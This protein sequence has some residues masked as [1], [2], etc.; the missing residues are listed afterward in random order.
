M[1]AFNDNENQS[2]RIDFTVGLIEEIRK[3]HDVDLFEPME[4]DPP[5]LATICFG[6]GKSLRRFIEILYTCLEGQIE[7]VG[8]EPEEFAGRLTGKVL[9]DSYSAFM[10]AWSDFSLSLGRSDLSEAMGKFIEG[11]KVIAERNAKGIQEVNAR[12]QVDL[13]MKSVSGSSRE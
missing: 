9:A 7:K 5:L 2:W 10:E 11:M 13:L 3:R 8:I 12:E 4:G 6:D 1:S